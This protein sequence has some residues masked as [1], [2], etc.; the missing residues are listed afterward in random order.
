M[1]K[2]STPTVSAVDLFCGAGGLTRGLIAAGVK[3]VAGIDIDPDAE[4]AYTANNGGA[5]YLQWDVSRKQAKTVAALFPKGGVRLLAGCAP[6]QP[7]SNLTNGIKRHEAWDLLTYFGKLVERIRP[8]LVTMENVPELARRGREV[9]DEFKASLER[10]GYKYDWRIVNCADYGV[11]QQRRRLVLLASR[12]GPIK[13][14]RGRLRKASQWVTVS[15]AIG[16]LPPVRSGEV[17]PKDRLH[18]SAKL[19]DL[20]LRRIRATAH[21]GGGR[22]GW[23]EELL[24]ECH[25]RETGGRYTSIYGRMAWDSPAPTMTTLCHNLGS[26]RF[27]HPEQDRAI[28]LR[29]ASLLQGFPRDYSFWPE[30]SKTNRSAVARLIGN[31]VP[32]PLAEALGGTLVRHAR[33]HKPK[34]RS[35]K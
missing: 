33:K 35:S 3:V 6:C 8:E 5:K 21:D 16:D 19:S 18:L 12:L 10:A 13:V 31:A 34:A 22:E 1:G 4:H 9:F 29:E 28:S 26:G 7:F 17:H 15:K 25:K 30:K 23:P 14:P 32:P 2:A 20:N 11:P 27:G 24:L